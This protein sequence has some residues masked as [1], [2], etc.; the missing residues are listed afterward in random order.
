MS[1]TQ[2]QLDLPALDGANPLGFLAALG[3]I[4]V[5]GEADRSLRLGWK[6]GAYWMPFLQSSQT[7]DQTSLLDAL[8]EKLRGRNPPADATSRLCQAEKR[9]DQAKKELKQ[10]KEKFKQLGLKKKDDRE[11][12]WQQIVAPVENRLAAARTD[13]LAALKDAVPSPELALGQ[14][15]DCTIEEFRNHAVAMRADRTAAALAA[16]GAEASEKPES[17]IIPTPFCFITGS[18]HQWFLDT[19]R[20]LMSKATTDKLRQALFDPWTYADEKLSMRWDPIEDRRYALMDRDPTAS[21][22]KSTTVWMANLLAYRALALFPCAPTGRGLEQAGWSG[23]EPD[24]FTWP[25]WQ[26]ALSLHTIR[27]LLWYP[28]FGQSDLGPWRQELRARGVVAVYRSRRI[29][30]GSGTM[31]K[32]NFTP[33]VM[34]LSFPTPPGRGAPPL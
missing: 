23:D 5:L 16:L 6:P 28:A 1:T 3:T 30:V 20:E 26:E 27:S 4:V 9:R 19:A 15:P 7:L 21:D 17:R 18:G 11:R 10:A 33:A 13:W 24:L 34:L 29:E 32:I 8:A 14:R 25:I 2:S 12:A 22:N 31:Q